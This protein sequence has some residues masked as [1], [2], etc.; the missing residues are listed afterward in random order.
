MKKKSAP[1]KAHVGDLKRRTLDARKRA[2]SAKKQARE[3][4]QNARAARRLFKEAKKV[5]KK[6][7]SDLA[8]LSKKLKKL[9]GNNPLL[10]LHNAVA[11]P[12]A[13]AKG[14][15]AAKPKKSQRVAV[16]AKSRSQSAPEESLS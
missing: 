1:A 15:Q 10:R 6:A 4:K 9:I 5:A 7:R 8:A 16:R 2:E 11:K 3:A 14:K 13:A 12:N